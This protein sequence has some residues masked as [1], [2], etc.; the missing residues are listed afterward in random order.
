MPTSIS[1]IKSLKAQVDRQIA[2]WI[3]EAK[4]QGIDVE[5]AEAKA[6]IDTNTKALM[7]KAGLTGKQLAA[8][9]AYEQS[10]I[11]KMTA[12]ADE[13]SAADELQSKIDHDNRHNAH[14][15]GI[16]EIE[17]IKKRITDLE[18][19]AVPKWNDLQDKPELF[20]QKD[21]TALPFKQL[22][23]TDK[24][25]K[26]TQEQ[27]T[28]LEQ[29][30]SKILTLLAKAVEA[31]KN[32]KDNFVSR[33]ELIRAVHPEKH[34]IESHADSGLMD[35]LKRLVSGGSADDLHKHTE[36]QL[37]NWGAVGMQQSVAD[38]KYIE[39]VGVRKITVGT[40]APT[41]PAE[42]DLFIDVS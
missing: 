12:E 36:G 28:A 17:P 32:V 19:K 10:A 3:E 26:E 7:K 40:V 1:K 8:L 27:L 11:E 13:E 42:G 4:A 21:I 38:A 24:D 41:N 30:Q 25:H 34:T 18:K 2:A 29:S 16:A 14:E 20:G 35:K 37:R 15:K 31:I 23:H 39:G 33:H 6:A 9:I 5:T 22:A